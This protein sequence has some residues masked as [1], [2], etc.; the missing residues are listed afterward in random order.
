MKMRWSSFDELSP[1][2]VYDLL[3]LRQEVFIVEQ[4]CVYLDADELDL[5]AFHFLGRD[6][7]NAL[8]AYA[9]VLIRGVKY[10]EVSIGRVVT[11]QKT[12]RSGGGRWLMKNVIEKIDEFFSDSS[13]NSIVPIRIS[14]QSYLVSFYSSFGFTTIGESYLEDDIPHIEMLRK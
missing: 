2:D 9:R 3:K 4:N 14:A 8:V 10:P 7:E 11:S 6:V 12:R 5:E 13:Q 1:R